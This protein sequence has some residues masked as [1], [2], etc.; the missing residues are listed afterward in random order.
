MVGER[1]RDLNASTNNFA[2]TSALKSCQSLPI[3]TRVSQYIPQILA[4]NRTF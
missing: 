4:D 1:E 3:T 2:A